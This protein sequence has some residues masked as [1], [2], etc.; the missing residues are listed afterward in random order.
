[1]RRL[2]LST[3]CVAATLAAS[4]V[5]AQ[6]V[7]TYDHPPTTEELK[8]ALNLMPA[9]PSP[10]KVPSTVPSTV[11]LTRSWSMPEP[12]AAAQ[13]NSEVPTTTA[14]STPAPS[15][16]APSAPAGS[17]AVALPIEFAFASAD[18]LPQSRPYIDS[19]AAL[20]QEN[21]ALHLGIEGHTDASGSSNQ[22]LVLSWSRALAVYK[23]L[24]ERG[25]DADRL[26]PL[27]K[28]SSAPLPGVAAMDPHNRRVQ[29]RVIN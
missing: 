9:P 15:T 8:K 12:K 6:S 17:S 27:G 5:G 10:E 7:T 4:A 24:L 3:V 23:A 1:M 16:P 2:L 14:P 13:P 18:F 21:P 22:N 25:I 28:G 19:I 20:L 11:P 26:A 29:F